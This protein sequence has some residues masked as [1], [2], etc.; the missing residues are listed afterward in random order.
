M[1]CESFILFITHIPNE[2]VSFLIWGVVAEPCMSC[3]CSSQ[4]QGNVW[5]IEG[6]Q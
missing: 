3:R 5:H 4:C 2:C 1:V 6:T